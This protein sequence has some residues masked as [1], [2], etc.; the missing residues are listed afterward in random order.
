MFSLEKFCGKV[1]LEILRLQIVIIRFTED[2]R[3]PLILQKKVIVILQVGVFLFL[4]SD[5]IELP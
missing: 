4:D 1:Y 5:N 3:P 2:L